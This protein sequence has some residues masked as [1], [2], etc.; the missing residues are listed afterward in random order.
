MILIY[1]R[2]SISKLFSAVNFYIP[3]K[4]SVK[5]KHETNMIINITRKCLY[6]VK[7]N[8]SNSVL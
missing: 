3:N 7:I 4:T 2:L 1:K 5:K 6:F 8:S